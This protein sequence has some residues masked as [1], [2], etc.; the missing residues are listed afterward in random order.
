MSFSAEEIA[1]EIKKHIPDFEITYVPD[2]RQEISNSWPKTIDDSLAREEWGWSP[3]HD[4]SST[5]KE[6]I[7][8]LSKKLL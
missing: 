6:M 5:T 7:K 1:A 4:L 3:K 8:I 2:F